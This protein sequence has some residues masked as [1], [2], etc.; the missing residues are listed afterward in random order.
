LQPK[1]YKCVFGFS[2]AFRNASLEHVI[3]FGAIYTT[4][5]VQQDLATDGSL[6]GM[7]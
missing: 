2:N 6:V 1:I 5:T 7:L 3:G 4:V